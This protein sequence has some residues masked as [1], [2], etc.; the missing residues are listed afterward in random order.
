MKKRVLHDF[1]PK[2]ILILLIPCVFLISCGYADHNQN[3]DRSI[4]DSLKNRDM[5]DSLK[6][7]L[8]VKSDKYFTLDYVTII[9]AGELDPKSKNITVQDYVE[10]G[11]SF[12][13]VFST[14]DKFKE[15][16]NG[17]DLGKKIIEISPYLILSVLNGKETLRINPGLP[18]EI[19][20]NASDLKQ[21]YKLEIE[22]FLAKMPK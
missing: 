11:K 3:T 15:S 2:V 1:H 10:N 21:I 18:D 9:L 19:Y 12:I 13:P 16:T 22:S 5:T 7:T 8:K 6:K 20:F 14:P 4:H 17:A